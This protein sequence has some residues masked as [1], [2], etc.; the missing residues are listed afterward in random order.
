MPMKP[1]GEKHM[2]LCVAGQSN[3]VG[4]DESRLP[5]DYGVSWPLDRIRQLGF[6]G[7]D[8][9]RIVPLGP[10]AQSFQD[11]RPFGHP[12]NPDWAKGTR[13]IQLPLAAAL[14]PYIPADYK[15]LVLS[16]AYGGTGFTVNEFGPYDAAVMRPASGIWRWGV[17]SNYYRAMRDRI[18][19]CLGLNPE[20][21]FLGVVWCQGE[22]DSA[23]ADGQAAGFEAL[24]ADFF[25]H[26]AARWPGRVWHG[27]W[28]KGCWY[29]FE[30]VG[31]WDTQGQ[32]PAIWQHYRAWNPET[33]VAVPRD[34]DSNEVNGTGITARIRAAHFGNGAF[35]KTVAPLVA[36]KI[37]QR[38]AADPTR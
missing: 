22:H 36:E 28:N 21:R 4:Y 14:V 12:D 25:A 30:T 11:M 33:Y 23:D 19:Y 6:W 13:G 34:T 7:E 31:Y 9:R 5:E 3:A 15:L 27:D 2:I 1:E 24:T 26:G 38:L 35:E 32:C 37:A 10:C 8:D 20:N 18:D 29:N 16:C 17:Q